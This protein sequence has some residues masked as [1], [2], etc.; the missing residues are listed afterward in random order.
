M[1]TH[2]ELG[3]GGQKFPHGKGIVVNSMTGHH[4]S[5]EPIPLIKAKAQKR[6]LD[7]VEHGFK[8]TGKKP[9]K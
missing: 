9:S 5:N 6:L 7:A 4:Y 3:S 8:P 2:I 1:P